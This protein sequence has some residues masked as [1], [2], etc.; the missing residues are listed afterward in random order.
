[1]EKKPSN[2]DRQNPK[3]AGHTIHAIS[4]AKEMQSK[5]DHFPNRSTSEISE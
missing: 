3:K 4:K 5:I 1:M 2:L